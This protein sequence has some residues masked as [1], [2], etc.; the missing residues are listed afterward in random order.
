[1]LSCELL[2]WLSSNILGIEEIWEVMLLTIRGE[3]EEDDDGDVGIGRTI[4]DGN[5]VTGIVPI[6]MGES[7]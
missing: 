2:F 1:M 7:G 5:K 6:V 3:R 4:S